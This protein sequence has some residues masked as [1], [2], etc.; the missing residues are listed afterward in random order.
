MSTQSVSPSR[1]AI[2]LNPTKIDRASL[3]DAVA[4]AE[5]SANYAE[6]LWFE[7]TLEV[8]GE[9]LARRAIDEGATVVIAAGGDGTVRS[10]IQGLRGS[11]VSLG[12]LPSGTGNLLA[13][14]LELDISK[15]DKALAVA[16]GSTE[17]TID[18]GVS[19]I[20]HPSGTTEEHVFV[21]MAGVGLDAKMI[22]YTNSKLKKAVGWLAYIDAGMRAIPSLKPMRIRFTVDGSPWRTAS[23]HTVM[24][25]NCGA[26]PGGVLLIPDAK[27]D[28]GKLDIMALRPEGPFGWIKVWNKITWENGVLRKSAAGRKIIDLNKDVRS[29]T[30]RTGKK[31]QLQLGSPEEFQLDGDEFGEVVAVRAWVEPLALTVRVGV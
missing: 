20:K 17:R 4:A 2:I 25:G 16:F 11:S 27:L 12:L 5:K 26:L 23:A 21:V 28:D 30:Y 10:V 15:V 8:T 29:V 1:A 18:I 14:N 6:T 7:T 31:L 13:R 3:S 19:S 22:A 9:E 24:I